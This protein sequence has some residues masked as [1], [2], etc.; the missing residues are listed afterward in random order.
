[1]K[2]TESMR[3][4]MSKLFWIILLITASTATAQDIHTDLAKALAAD[5]MPQVCNII[6]TAAMYVADH[7]TGEAA[8]LYLSRNG[9]IDQVRLL[10]DLGCDPDSRSKKGEFEGWTALTLALLKK[11]SAVAV[12]LLDKGA[13]PKLSVKSSDWGKWSPLMMA[14]RGGD[15]LVLDRIL[16]AG[17]DP[18]KRTRKNRTTALMMAAEAGQADVVRVLLDNGANPR[19]KDKNGWTPLFYA[20]KAASF[21]CIQLLVDAGA[22]VDI[23]DADQVPLLIYASKYVT[24][25]RKMPTAPADLEKILPYLKERTGDR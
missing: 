13:D 18:D 7:E 2:K 25:K 11:H 17:A 4:G 5:D 8:L 3:T 6:D 24:D 15:L 12:L 10:L 23:K 19:K 20:A 1:M 14:A 22:K 9:K 21:A 16:K